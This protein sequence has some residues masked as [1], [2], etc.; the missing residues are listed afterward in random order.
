[1]PPTFSACGRWYSA[2]SGNSLAA[3]VCASRCRPIVR[4]LKAFVLDE[5]TF[6]SQRQVACANAADPMRCHDP[7]LQARQ[8]GYVG[9]RL[10]SRAR[11]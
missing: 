2:I 1:M 6:Q 11:P 4:T 3:S 9:A 5:L 8:F 10:I 7:G